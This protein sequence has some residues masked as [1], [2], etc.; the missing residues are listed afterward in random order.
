[1]DGLAGEWRH[2]QAHQGR[3]ARRAPQLLTTVLQLLIT[4][5]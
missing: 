2:A 3:Q 4:L 5:S 1:V